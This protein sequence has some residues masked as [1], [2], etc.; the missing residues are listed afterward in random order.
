MYI[1]LALLTEGILF[2]NFKINETS[3]YPVK[4][5]FFGDYNNISVFNGKIAPIWAQQENDGLNIYTAII[6]E[7]ALDVESSTKINMFKAE[8][9]LLKWSTT[10]E[11]NNKGFEI[12]RKDQD[13]FMTIGFVEGKGNSTVLNNYSFT[14]VSS[15][16]K[17][18]TYRLKQ[19]D[20]NGLFNYSE[21]I[22]VDYALTKN[23]FVLEQNFPNPFNPSTTIMWK[24]SADGKVKLKIYNLLGKEIAVLVNGEKKAGL[25]SVTF[26]ASNM[27]SGVYFYRLEAAGYT[28]MKQM[29]LIK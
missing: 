5:N 24:Q 1:W 26:N 23:G 10:S 12:H 28:E 27:T 14:D 7:G 22:E 8:G 25:N 13:R 16:K 11:K 21:E 4:T 17:V 19:I 3:F 2:Y 6:N 20:F 9:N 18:N 15:D 29:M